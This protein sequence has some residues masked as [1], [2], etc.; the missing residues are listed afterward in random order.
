MG[1]N[2]TEKQSF[3]NG[4][5]MQSR[6][7]R[8][9]VKPLHS[10]W[11]RPVGRHS[12]SSERTQHSK[13]LPGSSATPVRTCV[14]SIMLYRSSLST[15]AGWGGFLRMDSCFRLP[16]KLLPLAL[17]M[18]AIWGPCSRARWSSRRRACTI[19]TWSKN[20]SRW[21]DVVEEKITGRW[22][23]G[24]EGGGERERAGRTLQWDPQGKVV[25]VQPSQKVLGLNPN[26]QHPPTFFTVIIGKVRFTSLLPGN[27][28]GLSVYLFSHRK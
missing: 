22:G 12:E 23:E 11:N 8:Q 2:C 14:L 5:L 16:L 21:R 27:V 28:G 4:L 13:L 9:Y 26:V 19:A 1:S 7:T 18:G 6:E 3:S 15:G 20:S 17:M 10:H 24:G 25:R